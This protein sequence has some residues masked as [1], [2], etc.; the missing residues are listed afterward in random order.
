MANVKPTA[1]TTT[2]STVKSTTS[3]GNGS[4]GAPS[5]RGLVNLGRA[6]P[7]ASNGNGSS[8]PRP[9]PQPTNRQ[10]APTS[11]TPEGRWWEDVGDAS[12]I[13]E[14]DR[15]R[16]SAAAHSMGSQLHSLG[17]FLYRPDVAPDADRP[18]G[19]G[20]GNG[21]RAAKPTASAGRNG[22]TTKTAKS[23]TKARTR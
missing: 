12:R 11:S 2:R 6:G 7:K 17:E 15:K 18:V 19:R 20:Q 21:T 8:N 22:N 3:N 1:K 10:L 23:T 13:S 4:T 5:G 16:M 9:T 14:R